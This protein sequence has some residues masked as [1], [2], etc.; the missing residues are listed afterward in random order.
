[1]ILKKNVINNRNKVHIH[2][3]EA[4][5]CAYRWGLTFEMIG[6]IFGKTGSTILYHFKKHDLP[7]RENNCNAKFREYSGDKNGNWRGGRRIDQEGYVHIYAPNH[8]RASSG[9]V[10]EHVLVMEKII[11]RF[12]VDGEVVHHINGNKQ[13]NHPRNLVVMQRGSHASLHAIE[14]RAKEK[15]EQGD[16]NADRVG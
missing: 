3:I 8:L 2:R 4:M 10:R 15:L 1:M 12:L 6:D 5:Y 13:D 14:K 16:D 11:G 7:R 9:V